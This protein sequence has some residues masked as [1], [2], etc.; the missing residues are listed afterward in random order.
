MGKY[1]NFKAEKGSL[2]Q[3]TTIFQKALM[4]VAGGALPGSVCEHGCCRAD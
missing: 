4:K 3:A 1:A 2:A